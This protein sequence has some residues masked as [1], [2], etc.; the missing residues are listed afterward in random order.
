MNPTFLDIL[1]LPDLYKTDRTIDD[2]YPLYFKDDLKQKFLELFKSHHF[3]TEIFGRTILIKPNLVMDSRVPGD[4]KCLT[5]HPNFILS[6]VEAV[7]AFKPLKIIIGDAP[8][9][10]CKWEKL[11]EHSFYEKLAHL[12]KKYDTKINLLDFRRTIWSDSLK[13]NTEIRPFSEYLIFDLKEASYLDPVTDDSNKFRV[14]NYDPDKLANYHKKGKHLYCVTKE[15][16]EADV[17]IQLPKVKTHQKAGITNA[18][19]NLVGINGDKDYLPHHK[20]GGSSKGG[21]CYPGSNPLRRISEVMLDKANR[22]IGSLMYYPWLAGSLFL[23]KV[24]PKS[25][26]HSLSAGWYGNDTTWRMVADINKIALFGNKNGKLDENPIRKIFTLCDGIIGGQGNGP[27][28]PVPLPL[29][30]ILFS[31]D[32]LLTDIAA[33]RLMRFDVTSIPLIRELMKVMHNNDHTILL[34]NDPASLEELKKISIK[35]MPAQGWVGH[36][37]LDP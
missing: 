34:N 21:D 31:D 22:N 19:K 25:P 18:L 23:W 3:E 30:T 36:L 37:E 33:A 27:L 6:A 29:G 24:V 11:F 16:F 14:T 8:V 26:Y 9:Q 10:S 7:L 1:Y 35:T 5:T 2:L 20:T 15:F 32:S 12:E 17:I 13:V 4:E 28:K